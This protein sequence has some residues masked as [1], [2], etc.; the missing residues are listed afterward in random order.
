MDF[1]WAEIQEKELL[2]SSF[3]QSA[4]SM[5]LVSADGFFIHVNSSF[6]SLLGYA[7]EELSD[8]PWKSVIHP[9][10][11]DLL[12]SFLSDSPANDR[13]LKQHEIRYICRNGET[14]WTCVS[15]SQITPSNGIRPLY[16][17]LVQDVTERK[18]K[19]DDAKQAWN[20]LLESERMY[21]MIADHS[22]DMIS[23]HDRSG[24]FLYV[25]PACR[26][27]LGYEPEE[28]VGIIAYEM[29]HPEDLDAVPQPQDIVDGR[30]DI[31]LFSY[32]FRRK[33]G[34][35]VWFE[36]TGSILRGDDG[37]FKEAL[38]TSRDISA[39]KKLEHQLLQTNE[40]LQQISNI[41]ALT[42]VA[43]RRRFDECYALE[44]RQALRFSTPLT[45]ILIDIDYFKKYND[46]YGHQK[47]DL[48]LQQVANAL[49]AAVKRPGDIIARYGG[50]EFVIV[51]PFTDK[52]GAQT[53]AEQL[54]REVESLSIPH[55]Q[56]DVSPVVTASLGTATVI[57]TLEMTSHELLLQ[58]DKALYQAKKD[59]RNRVKTYEPS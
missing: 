43:N 10:D 34:S 41:D 16:F 26:K 28:L 1:Q 25:S 15:I 33:D 40:L 39:R 29:L 58:A 47:G 45:V 35:Y 49:R 5:A 18:R 55:R 11:R 46:T 57:P 20:A 36:T 13:S 48:C 44:W 53:V 52:R 54:R 24:R 59:G 50:E 6:C 56:S 32:R 3:H 37:E 30:S 12:Y 42:G 8:K 4:L 17:K 38:C 22:T 31:V 7:E 51:L 9:D 2:A 21:R 14:L 27:L 23:K 19:E